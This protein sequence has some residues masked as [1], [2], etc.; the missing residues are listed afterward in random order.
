[1]VREK[2]LAQLRSNID[3]AHNSATP[4]RRGKKSAKLLPDLIS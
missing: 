2:K 1:M 3:R 4:G